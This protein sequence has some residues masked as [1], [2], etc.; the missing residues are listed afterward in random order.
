M[1][2]VEL[3]TH[4]SDD[5]GDCI[6]HHTHA[7]LEHVARSGYGALAVSRGRHGATKGIATE[8]QSPQRLILGFATETQ[9]ALAYS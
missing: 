9:S 5:P 7:L 4:T 6:P 1:I 2:K 3:H 8:A